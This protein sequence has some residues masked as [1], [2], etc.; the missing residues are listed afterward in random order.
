MSNF[1]VENNDKALKE[2]AEKEN[3]DNNGVSKTIVTVNDN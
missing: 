3:K 1:G 2:K